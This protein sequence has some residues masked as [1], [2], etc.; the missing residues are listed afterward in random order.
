MVWSTGIG[1][2]ITAEIAGVIRDRGLRI[3]VARAAVRAPIARIVTGAVIRV[4]LSPVIAGCGF[5]AALEDA[6]AVLEQGICIVIGR[7]GV[8]AAVIVRI[9]GPIRIHHQDVERAGA[10]IAVYVHRGVGDDRY[11]K[12]EGAPRGYVR[13]K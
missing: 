1:A 13:F 9:T 11:P 3:K 12:R 2:S 10:G 6:A 5:G 4:G 7:F 8:G